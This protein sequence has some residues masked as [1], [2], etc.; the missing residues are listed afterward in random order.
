MTSKSSNTPLILDIPLPWPVTRKF[1]LQ[2]KI[3]YIMIA[4]TI[5]E[6]NLLIYVEGSHQVI[7]TET[8]IAV[9]KILRSHNRF[10]SIDMQCILEHFGERGGSVVEC[11]TPKREVR[12]SR[13]TSAVLCP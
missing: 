10:I 3:E 7:L 2:T 12:G 4:M 9:N 1:P 6:P 5:A 11:R 8:Q 13:P